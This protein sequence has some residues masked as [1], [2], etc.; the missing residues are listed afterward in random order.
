MT[1]AYEGLVWLI[2]GLGSLGL[3][4]QDVV[5]LASVKIDYGQLAAGPVT[6][7]IGMIA[8]ASDGKSTMTLNSRMQ[9]RTE[10]KKDAILLHETLDM[11]SMIINQHIS[12][13]RSPLLTLQTLN[14][15]MKRGGQNQSIK[16]VFKDGNYVMTMGDNSKSQP[17]AENTVTF[18]GLLRI[19][20]LLPRTA[21]KGYSFSHYSKSAL[22]LSSR[23]PKTGESFILRCKGPAEIEYEGEKLTCVRFELE[24]GR[25]P[26]VFFVND[27]GVRQAEADGG[28]TIFQ[29]LSEAFLAK[30]AA[31]RIR[32]EQRGKQLADL[33]F[34][35]LMTAIA[36]AFP[37]AEVDDGHVHESMKAE[38]VGIKIVS[39]P[40]GGGP[41]FAFKVVK[42]TSV[43]KRRSMHLTYKDNPD[44]IQDGPFCISP[45]NS[46]VDK[47]S[48]TK[49]K[50]TWAA[51]AK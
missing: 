39:D 35:G 10:V 23:S 4:A 51:Y 3:Q 43:K 22:E 21:G 25:L 47:E 33:D 44:H 42:Y 5:P 7:G 24:N 27:D 16:G 36:K 1:R 8:K 30:E 9:T 50:E 32:D 6:Y 20:P 49:M 19:V 28:Q 46:N 2:I 31:R 14:M 41:N 38:V 18:N 11:M 12:C 40:G 26:V 48:I 37:D 45:M 13:S 17:F 15:D 29:P 34:G